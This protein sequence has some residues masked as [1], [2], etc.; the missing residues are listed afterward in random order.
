M[1]YLVLLI[2][3]IGV[4]SKEIL[5][6]SRNTI[7]FDQQFTANYIAEK[8]VEVAK[9][10]EENRDVQEF[11]IVINSPGGSV[12]AGQSFFSFLNGL[13]KKFHTITLFAA[14]MGFQMAQALGERYITEYGVLMSHRAALGGLGGQFPG[15]LNVRLKMYER[16]TALLDEHAARRSGM[17]MENY[18][19][20]VHD[21][22]W[23]IGKDAVSQKF[24][25]AVVAPKCDI[26]LSGTNT[27]NVQSLFG[28]F[29]VTKS[30]CP[31]IQGFLDV[32]ANNETSN[33]EGFINSIKNPKI[34]YTL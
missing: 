29:R 13:G 22:L 1:K 16:S 15:E 3:S 25:D 7:S 32:K 8:Q 6:T 21:E 17:T 10:V 18:R 28:N 30:N 34:E 33:L 19:K 5:L 12:F 27:T 23:L 31:L 2:L 20:L 14:S 4:F 11:Y 26:T 24:A 9:L